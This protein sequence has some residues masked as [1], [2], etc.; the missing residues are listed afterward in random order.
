MATKTYLC[1]DMSCDHCVMAI[2]R[3]LKALEGVVSVQADLST[4]RVVVEVSDDDVLP[5]VEATL[6]EIG[7]P[8]AP[9]VSLA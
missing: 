7:Y 9:E 4:K 2:E 6:K 3:E 1:P 5:Q 8:P